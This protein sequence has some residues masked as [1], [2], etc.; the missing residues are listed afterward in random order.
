VVLSANIN[1]REFDK[2][3]LDAAGLT[4]VRIL[5]ALGV[6]S[7]SASMIYGA[8]TVSTTAV[9]GAV[10]TSS[11]SGRIALVIHPRDNEIFWGSDASVTTSNGMPINADLPAI[12]SLDPNS[13]QDIYLISASS[14]D[15]RIVEI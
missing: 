4:T 9:I 6:I 12:F 8:K 1:N 14:T 10:S 5:N 11:K 13:P 7:S 2:F 3:A 15:V